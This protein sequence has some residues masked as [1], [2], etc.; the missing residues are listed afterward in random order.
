MGLDGVSKSQYSVAPFLVG[1]PGPVFQRCFRRI[2]C[3]IQVIWGCNGNRL[4]RLQSRWVDAI[5]GFL[6]RCTLAVDNLHEVVL[7]IHDYKYITTRV[8]LV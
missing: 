4:F 6:P 8:V 2:D 1:S 7:E 3:T 5:A